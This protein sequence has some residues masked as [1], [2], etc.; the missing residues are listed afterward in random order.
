M[1]RL[2]SDEWIA[3]SNIVHDFKY[4]YS[5]VTYQGGKKKVCII[6]KKHGIFE[7]L[8]ANHLFLGRGCPK[9]STSVLLT[10][11][12][13]IE[14]VQQKHG[15]FYD[16]SK[17]ILDGVKNK[18]L[19]ICPIH[20]DFK[21]IAEKHFEYGC[22]ACAK[23][24]PLTLVDFINRSSIIHKIKYDYSMIKEIN[25]VYSKVP[26][27][28]F[29]HG[30]FEQTVKNH[31]RGRGC[32]YCSVGNS[33]K[34]EQ[35]WLDYCKVPNISSHRNVY[36]TIGNRNFCVDGIF[37]SEKVIYEFLGDFWHGHPKKFA[38]HKINPRNKKKFSELFKNTVDRI[39]WF[40]KY[41]YKVI[42]IWESSY[43]KV[44]R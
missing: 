32:K 31:L 2:S 18:V 14:K 35:L 26:I 16:Y 29:R 9:C 15:N 41:G 42:S 22:S 43:N 5:E 40:R 13:W 33:S 34:K 28:C 11:D 39:R 8:A 17:V 21:Q 38:P 20:G 24:K 27:I 19:I 23:N 3:R 7:Q 30:Q 37:Q 4:D 12:E 1:Q 6:C 44:M 25:G 10:K 36:L